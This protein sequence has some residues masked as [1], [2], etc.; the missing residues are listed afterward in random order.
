M[1]KC[2]ACGNLGNRI[3]GR[4]ENEMET[5]PTEATLILGR[6]LLSGNVYFH[7]SKFFTGEHYSQASFQYMFANQL[8]YR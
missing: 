8:T 1:R 5:S 2:D 3:W 6:G 7:S 4:T